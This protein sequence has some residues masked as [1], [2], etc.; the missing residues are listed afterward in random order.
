MRPAE[1]E[2]LIEDLRAEKPHSS[3][4]IQPQSRMVLVIEEPAARYVFEAE[5]CRLLLSGKNSIERFFEAMDYPEGV[6][7]E[8]HDLVIDPESMTEL[9]DFAS[10]VDEM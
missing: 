9:E 7:V 5:E 4:V 10:T 2:Q 6:F 1:V 8:L 3:V